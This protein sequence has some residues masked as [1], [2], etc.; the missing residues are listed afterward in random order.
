MEVSFRLCCG[1]PRLLVSTRHC[2]LQFSAGAEVPRCD[3]F[4]GLIAFKWLTC[5]KILFGNC[6]VSELEM[7]GTGKKIS[8]LY[9]S[10]LA[11]DTKAPR[12]K[13]AFLTKLVTQRELA[14]IS[15]LSLSVLRLLVPLWVPCA[16]GHTFQL[17]L[18]IFDFIL[19]PV[20]YLEPLK[21]TLNYSILKSSKFKI[22]FRWRL[23]LT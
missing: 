1:S 19:K 22:T 2:P 17:L 5:Y 9:A 6:S 8:S 21:S 11:E 13:T 15:A 10:H 18:K 20:F 3:S 23:H 7:A 4:L 14:Q 16:P 12:S